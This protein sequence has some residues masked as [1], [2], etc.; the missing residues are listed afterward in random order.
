MHACRRMREGRKGS[1]SR[2]ISVSDYLL[3]FPYKF[4]SVC[5]VG[6]FLTHSILRRIPRSQE[7]SY[8]SEWKRW[9]SSLLEVKYSIR[10]SALRFRL[11]E[12]K[13]REETALIGDV[14]NSVVESLWIESTHTWT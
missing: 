13:R 2:P 4:H 8:T 14:T 10:C 7:D 6:L 1:I 11:K 3:F 5:F 9:K 12:E